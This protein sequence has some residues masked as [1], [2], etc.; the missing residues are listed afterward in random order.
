MPRVQDTA[1]NLFSRPVKTHVYLAP[2]LATWLCSTAEVMI[3][4]S[5]TVPS[6][7][8]SCLFFAS[9][10]SSLSHARLRKR[11]ACRCRRVAGN[12]SPRK[13]DGADSSCSHSNL[14]S[15]PLSTKCGSIINHREPEILTASKL[16]L[17]PANQTST[18]STILRLLSEMCPPLFCRFLRSQ[19]RS[20]AHRCRVI[21]P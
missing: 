11:K 2:H 12:A 3:S 21:S 13:R 7:C 17:Q 18:H 6:W 9:D 16:T 19:Q 8:H 4:L 15:R 1:P 10:R 5:T 14:R 20:K